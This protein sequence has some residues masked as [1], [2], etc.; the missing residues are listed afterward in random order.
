VITIAWWGLLALLVFAG[1]IGFAW[2]RAVLW[3]RTP[4]KADDWRRA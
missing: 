2:G 3:V 4:R 1:V